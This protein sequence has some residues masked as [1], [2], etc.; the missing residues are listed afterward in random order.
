MERTG[1]PPLA[2][3]S[4]QDNKLMM[5]IVYFA[6]IDKKDVIIIHCTRFLDALLYRINF[7]SVIENKIIESVTLLTTLLL[8]WIHLHVAMMVASRLHSR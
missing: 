3:K 7:F 5:M 1:Q 4:H 8:H 6:V 2:K